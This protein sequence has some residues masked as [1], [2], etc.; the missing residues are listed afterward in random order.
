M[1]LSGVWFGFP[2]LGEFTLDISLM[3]AIP[4]WLFNLKFDMGEEAD[5]CW[6]LEVITD[7]VKVFSARG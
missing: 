5:S 4:P 3:P 2:S 6:W 7:E 1:L